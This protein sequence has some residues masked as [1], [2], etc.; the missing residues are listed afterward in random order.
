[1]NSHIVIGLGFGDEGKGRTVDYLSNLHKT[2]KTLV[3]RFSGGQQ[4]GHQ[5]VTEEG[6][7]H[8]FSNFGSG[9]L[10]GIPTYWD[11]LCTF[12]PV[13]FT[14]E[15]KDLIKLEVKPKIFINS[16]CPVT[17][18]FDMFSNQT[19]DKVKGHGTCG[20]GFGA[21]LQR[22]E[23]FRSLVFEDLF[24]MTVLEI[25]IKMIAE[26]YKESLTKFIVGLTHFYEAVQGIEEAIENG[27]VEMVEHIP[28][29]YKTRIYE[30]SQ[31]VLLDQHHGFFPYVTRSNTGLKNIIDSGASINRVYFVTRAYQTRHGNGYMTNEDRNHNIKENPQEQNLTNPFQGNFRRTLLDLDLLKYSLMK[32]RNKSVI[33]KYSVRLVITCLDL[34]PDEYRFTENGQTISCLDEKDFVTEILKRLDMKQALLSRSDNG[35]FEEF[36]L[37]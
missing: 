3:V 23:D 8:V 18:V 25:K 21:T 28:N 15:L 7:R 20:M 5:V 35:D 31:G 26:Y 4:C 27:Y 32:E 36:N 22:E 17:T 6:V 1:M 29:K 16:K 11:K 33:G 24:N 9:T 19:M 34:I 10:R 14:E 30:G 12:E 37:L 13:S 2:M